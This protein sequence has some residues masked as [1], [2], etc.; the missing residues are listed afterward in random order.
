MANIALFNQYFQHQQHDRAVA[1]L[2]PVIFTLKL[3][4]EIVH[5][6]CFALRA[7]GRS[8]D[9]KDVYQ[10]YLKQ[11]PRHP[12]LL[13]GLGNLYMYIGNA[14]LAVTFFKQAN[15]AASGYF[16]AVY[17]LARAY[18]SLNQ[19]NQAKTYFQQAL[20]LKPNHTNSLN[21]LAS[22]LQSLGDIDKAIDVSLQLLRVDPNNVIALNNIGNAYRE[23]NQLNKALS[24][25]EKAYKLAPTNPE[26]IKNFAACTHHNQEVARAESLY[27]LHIEQFLENTAFQKEYA[28]F[29]WMLNRDDPFK[30]IENG[31][32][33]FPANLT[34]VFMY[35]ELLKKLELFDKALLLVKPLQS[36]FTNNAN[37]HA[38]LS[39]IYLGLGD[40][41]EALSHVNAALSMSPTPDQSLLN[42]FGYCLLASGQFSKAKKI[43]QELI[44]M[45]PD[46]QG[47]W[48]MYSTSLRHVDTELKDYRKLNNYDN[49]VCAELITPLLEDAYGITFYNDLK[50]D[51]DKL[52][53]SQ[54]FPIEQTLRNGTQTFEDLFAYDSE[55]LSLLRT[56][57]ADRVTKFLSGLMKQ[58]QHPFLKQ[59]PCDFTFNNSWSV[60]LSSNGFHKSHFH[61]QGWLSGVFYV[62]APK[63]AASGGQGW[64][65][66]GKSEIIGLMDEYDYAVKPESGLLVLFPSFFWHGTIPF[67]SDETRLSVVVDIIPNSTSRAN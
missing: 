54:Q 38:M 7:L 53:T 58:S 56:I 35:V 39:S 42:Q 37:L 34:L 44:K 19:A 48:T 55:S 33:L 2:S 5:Q 63:A 40:I 50:H 49:L 66:F 31:I 6:Y 59:L 29:R 26:I 57:I 65:Q 23:S 8:D 16:D 52:H 43:Y 18:L 60:K 27:E 45:E 36:S 11:Y 25:F 62:E 15:K 1:E 13:N 17:N 14:A 22:A 64:L 10:K 24:H 12:L 61:E 51:L 67:E 47:W 32:R 30:Y 21:G 28:N 20:R 41:E 3:P 4:A 46:N 9:A